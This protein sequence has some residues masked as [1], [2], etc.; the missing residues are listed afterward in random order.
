MMDILQDIR[1]VILYPSFF[2][3]II[4]PGLVVGGLFILFV[5]WFERKIAARVQMRVGPYYVSR[6]GGIAQLL[7]DAIRVAL[8]E[9]IIPAGVNPTLY[10]IAPIFPLLFAF[11]PLAF[12]PIGVIPDQGSVFSAYYSSFFDPSVGMGVIAA[13]PTE[14]SLIAVLAVEA[15]YPIFIILQAWATNNRFALVGAVRE[16]YLSVAYDVLILMS[17]IAIA[18]EYHTLD[19]AKV[20]QSGIP[21]IVANPL[22]AFVFFVGLIMATSRFPFEI[23]EAE[24]ELVTGPATEYSGLLIL[25]DE[26]DGINTKADAGIIEAVLDL[27]DKT[28]Q[29]IILTANDP[30][31]PQLRPIREKVKMIE[32][33]RLTKYPLKRILK[34]IC[35]GEKIQCED[36]A[37]DEIIELSEGD[38]RYAINTLQ[39]IAE[40]YGKVTTS[41]VK[42]LGRRKDR[43][44]DPFEA[45]RN[46][47][48]ARYFWQAKNAVTN[49][50]IDYELLM[51]WI[52][53]NIPNQYENVEDIY[54]AYDALSRASL[55]L[56]RAKLVGWDLLNYVFEL[57][58]P[59]VSF[60]ERAKWTGAYKPKWKK[61]QFPSY[62]QMLARSKDMRDRLKTVLDKIGDQIHASRE[63]TL[64][65]VL[66]FFVIIYGS[67]KYRQALKKALEITESEEEVIR[68][69]AD[70]YGGKEVG[71]PEKKLEERAEESKGE[72]VSSRR[73]YRS[74]GRK[75]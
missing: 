3:M 10:V 58:G 39:G 12:L 53:E 75:R 40:G 65:D 45:L 69:L 72:R 13:L 60:A 31:D 38:A 11:L 34:R 28:R 56:T 52:D 6:F 25:L 16:A 51:R 59:G 42:T 4:F 29:P 20:V 37:L 50:Q 67:S 32:V 46:M 47:F 9:I 70:L 5:I 73:A 30:W 74:F 27:I 66:P 48:W 8:Q 68:A 63:K 36:E 61:F 55:F 33:P 14:Y 1:Y 22:A 62:I 23:V 57:M 17:V 71:T 7:A 19:V 35:E 18:V 41:M 49:T 21:G 2:A 26:M 43:E 64:N 24:S 54:R 15:A 44:L